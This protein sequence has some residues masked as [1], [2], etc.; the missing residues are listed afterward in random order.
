[1]T[2]VRKWKCAICRE[3]DEAGNG[4]WACHADLDT[5]PV[6]RGKC[7]AAYQRQKIGRIVPVYKDV[8]DELARAR[9][10][11]PGAQNS[12]HEGWAV[13]QE[14]VDELWDDV[15]A[16]ASRGQ[17]RKEAIQI[18]AM[19]VRFIEDLCTTHDKEKP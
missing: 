3:S 12:P 9:R 6:H 16:N 7:F 19:A 2:R 8:A 11:F 17:M 4:A 1:M 10:K 13:I 15:K 5:T 18:A 14:E